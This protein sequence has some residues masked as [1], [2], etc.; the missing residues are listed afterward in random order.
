VIRRTDIEALGELAAEALAGGGTLVRE[1]H[2]GIAARPFG[3]L[4]PAAAPARVIHDGVSR[5]VYTGVLEG[6]R[7]AARGGARAV[8]LRAPED[9]PALGSAV[10]GSIALGALNGVYGSHLQGPVR[11]EMEVRRDGHEVPLRPAALAA[12]YPDAT[13]R[14][15]VFVHGLCETET[16]WWAMTRRP[17][18][19][20][21]RNYGER[22]QDEL[23][24]T[25]VY[26]RYN[27]GLHV[28]E[29]GLTLAHRVGDLVAAWP[30]GVEEVV[31][32]GHWT[33]GLVVRSACQH[34]DE[35]GLRWTG[36]VRHVFCL[37]RP[38]LA[39]GLEQGAGALGR[40]LGRLPETRPVAKFVN[41]RSAGIKALRAQDGGR[42]DDLDPSL[43]ERIHEL[44]GVNAF[45]LLNHPAVY[46]QLRSRI[47][48]RS[49]PVPR[50]LPAS[51]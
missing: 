46:R 32:V 10:P 41:G 17:D 51:V 33:G 4:G 15:V 14:I 48:Q 36:L 9:G 31:L 26:L 12:A 2:E 42:D 11:L 18:G 23:S 25:P 24:F 7:A 19:S 27:T 16:A 5:A 49:R 21:R 30:V 50:A 28:S 37:G 35:Q 1:V 45:Q 39:A 40:A 29:N 38:G 43:R 6:L 22:L 47:T 44:S 20:R 13:S 3:V 8:A 34:A